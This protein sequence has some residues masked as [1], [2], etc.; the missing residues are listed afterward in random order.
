MCNRLGVDTIS[1]GV[2]LGCAMELY[3]KGLIKRHDLD[4]GPELRFGNTEALIYYLHCLAYRKGFGGK[5]AEGS[6]VLAK[7]Y[8][9]PEL[10]MS[11]KGQELPAYDP[12]GVQGQGLSY[13]TSNRGGCHVRAYMIAPE[14]LGSLRSWTRS[15]PKTR[16][17]G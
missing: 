11:V 7:D 1:C 5:L 6:A 10:S 4:G 17:S 14:V 16:R 2:T 3:E 8:G 12:R 15:L 13:A 9:A